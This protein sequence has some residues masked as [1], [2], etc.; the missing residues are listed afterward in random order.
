MT[1][2]L[3]RDCAGCINDT[4]RIFSAPLFPQTNVFF[5]QY[6]NNRGNLLSPRQTRGVL[7]I[8]SIIHRKKYSFRERRVQEL[9]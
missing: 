1:G 5:I 6:S 4:R 2:P 3:G 9:T 7:S 8:V